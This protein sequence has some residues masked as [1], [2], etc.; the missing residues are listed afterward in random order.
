MAQKAPGKAHRKGVTLFE[1]A[2]M[3]RDEQA[4][5]RWLEREFWP[6]G[7]FCPKC[8]SF[9]VQSDIK[10][11]S[12][13]HRC[14]DCGT[15]KT[16]TMF[17]V[18]IG[19]VMEGTRLPYRSWAIAIYLL[20]TNLKGVSS[21]KLHREL[22]ITQKSAWFMLHR[23]RKAAEASGT[24]TFGGP[25]EADE[26]YVGGK[27]ANM[28]NAKR[29]ELAEQG[30]GRGPAGK[31]AVVGVK[32]RETKQVRAKVTERLDAP[33]LQGFV[34]ENTAPDAT[35]YTDE[36]S[37][38]EGLPRHHESVKHSASEYVRGQIHTN[39]VESFWSMMKRG[40][41]GIYHKMSPKHLHR[42]VSEFA[43]RHNDRESDTVDQMGNLV[44]GMAGKQLTYEQLIAP[45]N[46]H[47]GADGHEGC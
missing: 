21:M 36:A 41:I 15:G 25:V 39:G 34:V 20:T 18:R 43:G 44:R 31:T 3:F 22:G 12:A 1:V 33:A 42:Y 11:K 2:E 17:T 24:A 27:R 4:A 32:D 6:D 28:S 35:V 47:F 38:Y 29:H 23:L 30:F 8:G 7:P 10:H 46:S 16:K 5:R 13:T 26:T 14:R 37:A 40:Y 45:S 9:N 19:T